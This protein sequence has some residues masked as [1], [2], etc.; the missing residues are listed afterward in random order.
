[1]LAA[2]NG[3]LSI[4]ADPAPNRMTNRSV[5]IACWTSCPNMNISPNDSRAAT[6]ISMPRKNK[7]EG[8][9]I[10]ERALKMGLLA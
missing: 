7:I 9:S 10:F 4:T 2:T 8:I 3:T 6:V 5:E 1:M